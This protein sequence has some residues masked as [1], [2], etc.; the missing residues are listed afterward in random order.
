MSDVLIGL[1]QI[2]V[3]SVVLGGGW[4]LVHLQRRPLDHIKRKAK[5]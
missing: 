3:G 4:W 5:N 2:C 1:A